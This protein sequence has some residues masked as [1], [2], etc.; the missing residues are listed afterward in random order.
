MI[1][2][3]ESSSRAWSIIWPQLP[4]MPMPE[5]R[6]HRLGEH[7]AREE[8][9]EGDHDEV[10]QVR[11][12]VAQHDARVGA[13]SA[14]AACHVV[15]LAQLERLAARRARA[16]PTQPVTPSAKQTCTGPRPS[17][18]ISAISSSSV[19]IE[20]SVEITKN[21]ASSIRPPK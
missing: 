6:E 14:R 8:Q 16:K 9:H 20:E 1:G 2:S 12:D 3:R 11:Q 18:M 13:P 10:H 15:E 21:T 19:G 7:Q 4:S 17:T 5:P